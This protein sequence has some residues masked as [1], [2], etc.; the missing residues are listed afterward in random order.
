MCG[1]VFSEKS[2]VSPVLSSLSHRGP[3]G[4]GLLPEANG[5]WGHTR[6]A[7]IDLNPESA[8]PMVSV[9]GHSALIFN[10]EI[11]N[12]QSLRNEL[13]QTGCRFRSKGDTEVVLNGLETVGASF[14]HRLDG[15]FAFVYLDRRT[16]TILLGR[17]T[18]GKNPLYYSTVNGLM[19]ASEI[20]TLQKLIGR[21]LTLSHT[22][23][24]QYVRYGTIPE[25]DTLWQEV[26][27]FPSGCTGEWNG[28]RLQISPIPLP[29]VRMSTSSDSP[30]SIRSAVRD[31][32]IRAVERRLVADV[33]VATFLSGGIDSS[34]LVGIQTKELGRKPMTVSVI[35]DQKEHSEED[36]IKKIVDH[37]KP[38]HQYL[39]VGSDTV[40]DQIPD[41]LAAYDHPS[42]DGVNTWLVSKSVRARGIKVALSGVGGD[43]LFQGY[44]TFS[45]ARKLQQLR[46]LLHVLPSTLAGKNRQWQRAIES[47]AGNSLAQPMAAIRALYP[48]SEIKNLTGPAYSGWKPFVSSVDLDRLHG[49]KGDSLLVAQEW[50]GYMKQLL[51]R[52]TNIMSMA[53]S[54]EVRAPFTDRELLQYILSVPDEVKRPTQTKKELLTTA[55]SDFLIQD[56]VQAPK[57]GFLLPMTRWMLGPLKP[58]M[59]SQLESLRLINDNEALYR[60]AK[61]EWTRLDSGT[62][63]WSRVWQWVVLGKVLRDGL[64]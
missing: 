35:F 58:L 38:D 15:M 62:T 3:D 7:I 13:E 2:A 31:H 42:I 32:V 47:A 37:W 34:L 1:I 43:E 16:G 64:S 18:A 46:P 25:P 60:F 61:S 33:P 26:S 52:D 45:Q 4:N 44:N 6:L 12:Y 20:R 50:F 63:T 14:A 41:A 55:C 22:G 30:D 54:L 48:E 10:G 39:F 17:D 36:R 5:E 40:L 21:P 53:S 49:L 57:S 9:S 27:L 29:S 59:L 11:Y 56:I 19:V 28:T 24:Q 23:L 51:I 8:Q